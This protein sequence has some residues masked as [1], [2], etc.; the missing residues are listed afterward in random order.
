MQTA[1]PL[2]DEFFKYYLINLLATDSHCLERS[3]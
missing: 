1:T 3:Q 2:V